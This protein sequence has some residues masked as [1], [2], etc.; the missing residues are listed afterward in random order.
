MRYDQKVAMRDGVRLSTD[1][2]LPRTGGDEAFPT[3]VIP[4]ALR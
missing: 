3:I 4:D 2:Y 1:L